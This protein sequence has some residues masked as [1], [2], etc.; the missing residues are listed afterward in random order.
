MDQKATSPERMRSDLLSNDR[1]AC[2]GAARAGGRLER[3]KLVAETAAEVK[4]VF[5]LCLQTDQTP[6]GK[7][8][9]GTGRTHRL[10]LLGPSPVPSSPQAS[11]QKDNWAAEK[12]Q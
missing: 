5:P 11:E 1:L 10:L 4:Q 12:L 9:A 6:S 8:P 3:E 2:Q 7:H